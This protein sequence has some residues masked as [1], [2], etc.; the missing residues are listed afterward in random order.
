MSNDYIG[1]MMWC[2]D[3]GCDCWVP[4]ILD[5]DSKEIWRG[6]FLEHPTE[7]QKKA[8]RDAL[9]AKCLELGQELGIEIPIIGD[10]TYAG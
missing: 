4:V 9:R 8:Q 5:R 6:T 3:P 2:G 10:I 1:T 7:E